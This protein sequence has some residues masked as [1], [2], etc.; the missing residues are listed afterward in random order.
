MSDP[1]RE[2][3][4]VAGQAGTVVSV[5]SNGEYSFTKPPRDEIVLITGLGVAGDV[6]A[7]VTVRHRSRVAADPGQPNLRQ[8]HLIH[9]ELHDELRP[10][11]YQVAA[12]ALG[13]NVTTNGIDLLGLPI[14][15]ILRFGAPPADDVPPAEA[16]ATAP[17]G[18]ADTRA[19][20]PAY[21]AGT[22]ADAPAYAAGT[23]AA[24]PA[25]AGTRPDAPADA[26]GTA[27]TAGGP[28][29]GAAAV[30]AAAGLATL[31]PATSAAVAILAARITAAADPDADAAGPAIVVT[32]LRNP[33]QQINNYRAGLLK[34]VLGQ[35]P[36]GNLVRKAGVMAVVLRGGRIRPGDRISVELPPG[37]HL[38][39][40]P[41]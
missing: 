14:G 5:N 32:G 3:T 34:R 36:D 11:G 7:G 39:L 40:A 38:P 10:Q 15:T 25:D 4:G 17:A 24:A 33:C 13:E 2:S 9:A 1:Q 20:G 35:D 37:P 26:A 18:N 28:A 29:G 6:H 8:V 27:E 19:D 12:G 22:G 16:T 23:R 21:A 30:V 41:V 31:N